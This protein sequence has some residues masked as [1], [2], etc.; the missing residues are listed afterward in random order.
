MLATNVKPIEPTETKEAGRSQINLVLFSGG[1]GTQSITEALLKHP[2]ISLTI[3]INAYDDGHS[4]GRLRRFIPGMLG[5]SDVRKNINRLMPATE[6]C[7]KALKRISDYRLPVAITRADAL[8]FV[9]KCIAGEYG[10][11]PEKIAGSFDQL[12]IGQSRRLC[13]FLT[14]FLAY[15]REQESI[16]RTFDFTD[17]AI[18]NLL[19]AGCYLQEGRDFNR[20]IEAFSRFYEVSPDILLNI[21][22][23][24]NLF[25][26]AEKENGSV[27]LSEADLVAAQDAA[28][29]SDL[30]LLDEQTYWGCV[31]NAAEPD[32][33]WQ[34]LFRESHCVPRLNPR[35]AKA[36]ADADVIVYGPGTQHS[37]LFPSYMTEGVAEAIAANNRADKIFIGNIHRDF[38]IQG[39][40]ANDLAQK[41][42]SAFSRKG[43]V[44]VSWLDVVSHFFVQRAEDNTLSKAKYV[45]FD[46]QRFSFP[47]ETVKARD[48]E[49]QEGRHSGGYVLDELHQLIQAKIDVELER[50]HH[51]VSIIVPV[52]N[53]ARTLEQVLKS[54]SALDFQPLGLT[55]EIIVVDGRSTDRSVEIARAVTNIR[56]YELDKRLG[57]GAAL[58]LGFSKARGN[59]FVSFPGD[60][61]YRPDD[62]Y[63]VVGELVK[64]RFRA[65]FGTRAVKCTNLSETLKQI[66]ENNW[67]LYVM[68]KYGGI[69][70]SVLTLLL[71]NRYVSDVLTS[72]KAFDA[73]LL[74]S[75]DLHCNGIDLE[76]EIVAKLSRRREYMFELPVDYKPRNRSAG[77]K[78]TAMDGVKAMLA[79]LRYRF[80]SA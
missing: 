12:S 15:L 16:G 4:T 3:V 52:L 80:G 25:L 62:L 1:S 61:E 53:E 69:L 27:L 58:R 57:R 38:D 28:K 24:E 34:R 78:I 17:C 31:E 5:P 37:S 20:T 74:R 68:S 19:F 55:K 23:G 29:I 39:D 41:L 45:P 42:L 46:E 18:G 8:A 76:T 21:T 32:G 33:G 6:R 26:V 54:V 30:F 11:L 40:D 2:Q 70:L 51:M 64:S 36:L 13:S 47:L 22:E 79:L 43:K 59:I 10:A 66:Y 77:K 9:D 14:T 65:V 48:W 56:V 75:L 44:K 35:A 72:I 73:H 7:H 67:R 71:Y 63:A 49:A 50:L 60:N